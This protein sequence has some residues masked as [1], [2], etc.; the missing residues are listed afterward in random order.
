MSLNRTSGSVAM[1]V[2]S[3]SVKH[4]KGSKV[5]LPPKRGQVKVRI[6]RSFVGMV[7]KVISKAV[8]LGRKTRKARKVI[9]EEL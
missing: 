8:A 6:A 4:R 3:R 9:A 5:M 1:Y 2:L 7:S